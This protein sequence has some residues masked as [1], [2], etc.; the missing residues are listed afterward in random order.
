MSE[1]LLSRIRRLNLV[2]SQ[3]ATGYV[4]FDELCDLISDMG[5]NPIFSAIM[6]GYSSVGRAVVSKTTCRGFEPFCP[7]QIFNTGV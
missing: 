2:L 1:K 6:Q 5:S 7:C 3:S 4:S